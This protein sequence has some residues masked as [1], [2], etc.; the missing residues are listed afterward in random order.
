MGTLQFR[1]RVVVD[2]RAVLDVDVVQ[3]LGG[4]PEVGEG[5]GLGETG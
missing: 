2:T 1:Y 3:W 5:G 4:L